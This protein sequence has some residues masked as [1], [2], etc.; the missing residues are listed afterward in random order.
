[1]P[2][3]TSLSFG[4]RVRRRAELLRRS[5]GREA[6]TSLAFN[7]D[8]GSGTEGAIESPSVSPVV[9]VSTG[10]LL[11][12]VAGV[13]V[14]QVG[15]LLSFTG[16]ALDLV[17]TLLTVSVVPGPSVEESGVGGGGQAAGVQ[18][19]TVAA[20]AQGYGVAR[21]EEGPGGDAPVGE[22]GRPE[23][24]PLQPEVK[25]LPP[26]E[27]LAV[28]LDRAWRQVRDEFLGKE[29]QAEVVKEPEAAR[30]QRVEPGTEQAQG[31]PPSAFRAA[32][33]P[34][35][36][37]LRAFFPFRHERSSRRDGATEVVD[38]ALEDLAAE[39]ESGGIDE[40]TPY[41]NGGLH[42]PYGISKVAATAVVVASTLGADW[43]RRR[44][45]RRVG[46]THRL[47]N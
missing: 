34:G 31:D 20:V 24:P 33:P 29:G 32:R 43:I 35:C 8:A 7:L 12:Q 28:G 22:G 17:T 42:P 15:Q 10:G 19:S 46:A 11:A 39:S 36:R 6:A 37:P 45:V 44:H 5:A 25:Q 30:P 23:G 27:R 18:P 3:P 1:M 9:G 2:S 14:Q 26:W 41:G 4:G 47:M 13:A 38:A 16:S 21:H 40:L